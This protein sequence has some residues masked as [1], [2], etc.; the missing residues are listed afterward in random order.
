MQ[1]SWHGVYRAYHKLTTVHAEVADARLTPVITSLLALQVLISVVSVL[2]RRR[3][4]RHGMTDASR[5][6][7]PL[8]RNPSTALHDLTTAKLP[9]TGLHKVTGRATSALN[10]GART[11][12][13]RQSHCWC[14][15][16]RLHH[17]TNFS[18][19]L[20]ESGRS[21]CTRIRGLH[22]LAVDTQHLA[23]LLIRMC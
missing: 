6:S 21:W 9:N 1:E 15:G 11:W 7:S 19:R 13:R 8:S 10:P 17:K 5:K 18:S 22:G 23:S 16:R 2:H 3:G 12:W 4:S 20:I 14:R